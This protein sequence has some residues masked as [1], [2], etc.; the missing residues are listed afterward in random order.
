MKFPDPAEECSVIEEI[1]TLVSMESNFEDPLEKALDLDPLEDEEGKENMA[2]ME[3]N[4]RN[5]IQFTQ[6]ESLELEV[7]PSHLKYVYL[8]DCSTLPTVIST[9]LTKNQEEQLITILKK[10]KKAIGWTIVDIRGI[11][12]FCMHKIILEEGERARIDGKRRLNPIM[13]EV[14]RKEVIKWLDAGIIYSISDSSWVSLVQCEP[15]KGGIMIVENERSELIP[16]RSVTGWRICID[17]RKLNKAALKDHF[18]LPFMDQMLDRLANGYSGYNQTVVALEEQ[19]KITFTCPYGT[20]AFRRMPCNAPAAFQ[21][22]MMAI[23]TN[24]VENFVD[25]FM[26]DFFIFGNTYDICLSNLAKVLKRCEQTNL[27]LN[28]EKCHLMGLSR[29]I[30][31]RGIEVDKAKVDVTERLSAPINVKGVRSFLGHANFYRGFTKDFSKISKQLCLLLEKDIVFD[32][33][34]ARL[35]AFEDLKK[36]VNL[37]PN[38][39]YT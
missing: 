36:G 26:D 1:E 32:F 29:G 5:F 18:S 38:N 3:S 14:V 23:F 6:F 16:T 24:M 9:E 8:G 17:Y 11:S 20:F 27:V 19:Q 28:W 10:F 21:R 7:L 15:K 31:T 13:K 4:P 37:S 35:E 33:N 22:C 39:R 2:L 25:V 30:K 34:K 12:P